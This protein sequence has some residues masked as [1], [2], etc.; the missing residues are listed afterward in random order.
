MGPGR[1]LQQEAGRRLGEGGRHTVSL[2]VV[3][4]QGGSYLIHVGSHIT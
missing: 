2:N 3:V 4:G 1:R